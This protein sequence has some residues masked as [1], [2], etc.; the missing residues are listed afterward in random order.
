MI[1]SGQP[2]IDALLRGLIPG[3]NIVWVGSDDELW[4]AV[5]SRF[6]AAS[7]GERPALFV[8]CTPEETRRRLPQHVTMI[9]ASAASPYGRPLPLADALDAYVLAN[10]SSAITIRGFADLARRWGDAEAVAFFARTCPT[11]LQSGALT[12]WWLPSSL[13][14]G[15]LDQIRHVTQVMLEVRGD[16]LHVTKAESR[17]ATVVG[18]VH[19][20]G[21][22]SDELQLT[23]RPSAGRLARGLAAVRRDLGLSQ[24]QLAQAAGVTPSAISQAESG[25]RGLSVDTLIALAERLD[26]SLDRLVTAHPR[27][28]Y[29]LAR[30]DR[31]RPTVAR[32]V[33]ALVDDAAGG[34]RAYFV[35]LDGDDQGEPP[36]KHPGPELIAVVRGLIQ[37]ETGDDAP[38]LRT[39][40]S[41]L[42]TTASIVRWRNLRPEPAA[43]YW[44]LRD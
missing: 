43:L 44:I 34:L 23:W 21:L 39:G 13:S 38:V 31:S 32:G 35:V 9:D 16:Q 4:T 18:S 40:D 24:A 33:S 27:P 5:E 6:L 7:A 42:A 17:P 14:A 10:A 36:I 3:D 11:M 28:G 8:A 29:V 12:Y 1:A 2:A 19:E 20:V 26:I 37:V 41:L 30:H 22:Q 15:V 25:A